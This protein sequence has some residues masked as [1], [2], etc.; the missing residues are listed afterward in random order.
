MSYIEDILKQFEE[1]DMIN[2]C[3]ATFILSAATFAVSLATFVITIVSLSKVPQPSHE[4]LVEAQELE[5]QDMYESHEVQNSQEVDEAEETQ[6]A[7]EIPP[8]P[9]VPHDTLYR[10]AENADEI[11][12]REHAM[13]RTGKQQIT[14]IVRFLQQNGPSTKKT[15]SNAMVILGV[16][17]SGGSTQRI[18]PTVSKWLYSNLNKGCIIS[19]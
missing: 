1:K 19:N 5:S 4:I 13:K 6:E 7:Q 15:I 10:A 11:I 17:Y 12:M 2:L 18:R 3:V 16:N 14:A 8:V 9:Q